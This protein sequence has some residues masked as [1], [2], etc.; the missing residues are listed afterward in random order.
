LVKGRVANKLTT[1]AKKFFLRSPNGAACPSP[2][3][4]RASRRR[5]AASADCARWPPLGTGAL[6]ETVVGSA[7]AT[8]WVGASAPPLARPAPGGQGW[9]DAGGWDCVKSGFIFPILTVYMRVALDQLRAEGYPVHEEDLAHLSP[10]RFEH[11]NLFG[12]YY[13]PMNQSRH[14]QGLR[15]LRAV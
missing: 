15:P 7:G 1:P 14:R 2:K 11:I 8:G 12:K 3:P 5:L 10:A 4:R 13:F 6:G 9:A